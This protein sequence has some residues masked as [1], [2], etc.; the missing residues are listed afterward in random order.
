DW[1]TVAHQSDTN[2]EALATPDHLAYV[3]YTSGST[4]T[5]KGVAVSQRGICNHNHWLIQQLRLGISDRVLLRTS[6]SFDASV[7][8]LFAPLAAGAALVLAGD[9]HRGDTAYIARAIREHHVTVMQAVPSLLSVLL[10]EQSFSECQS[11]RYVICGGEALDRT[12]ARR[13]VECLPAATLANCY[14]PTEASIGTT[15]FEI[16]DIATGTGT[17]PIG[18]PIGN[19]RC[20]ILDTELQPVPVGVIGE[21]H[22]GGVGLARGYL[23]RPE[24][25]AERFIA[26]PFRSGERLYRTGDLA[27]YLPDGTIEYSGRID[28]QVKLRGFRIEPG[29]IESALCAHAEVRQCVV[30]AREDHPGTKRLVAYAVVDDLDIDVSAL[31]EHLRQR[32]PEHMIPSVIVPLTDLPLTNSGKLNR[33]ALPEPDIG[34]SDAEFVAPRSPLEHNLAQIWRELL[35]AERIGV[36]DN[37]FDLGGHS[38]LATRMMARLR[39]NLAA[40]V[41]LRLLFEAPTVA[42]LAA[43]I[44]ASDPEAQAN[45]STPIQHLAYPDSIPLS[46]AQEGLWF[47]DRLDGA[48]SVYNIEQALKLDGSLR[49]DALAHAL[50]GLIA[51]HASLRTGFEAREG[52]AVQVVQ[53]AA[54]AGAGLR[55]EVEEVAGDS[56]AER[57]QALNDWLRAGAAEPFDLSKPPLL[58]AQLLRLNDQEQVLLLVVHHIVSDGWSMGILARELGALYTAFCAGQPDPLPPLPIQFADYAL[59]QRQ[60]LAGPANEGDLAYW[61]K[62]LQAL[63]ALSLPTDRPRPPRSSYQGAQVRFAIAAELLAE[64]K[65]LARRENVT[66]Y[67]LLLAAFQ[68][69]LMRYSGQQDVVV[70]TAVA[71]RHRP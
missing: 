9:N 28:H 29:E 12:L 63:E 26:D 48:S 65:A 70:G 24:L 71:G 22:I 7:W 45:T 51:R 2:P 14:G 8:E 37:F 46:S 30:L 43:R 41:P 55:L 50:R 61:R 15:C 6:I 4:G 27:R 49:V 47:I 69:L 53:S 5:P 56:P 38:L 35:G 66:L 64:L 3:I 54:E 62:Q 60:R 58:R 25:T 36:H 18:K 68:V 10:E 17:V 1:P 21:L 52:V 40:E 42:E 13:F 11:L 19:A 16:H 31:T 20:H 67:M 34:S 59:W 32:L 39:S 57:E 33:K 23:N 44:A